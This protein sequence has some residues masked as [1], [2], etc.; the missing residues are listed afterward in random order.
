MSNNKYILADIITVDEYAEY[1]V[2]RNKERYAIIGCRDEFDEDI[3]HYALTIKGFMVS[4]IRVEGT[5]T[6]E[7]SLPLLVRASRD[8]DWD[9]DCIYG[10]FR[11]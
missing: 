10:A 3:W 4:D 11:I 7:E 9:R 1:L 6:P 8:W 2:Q 5:M